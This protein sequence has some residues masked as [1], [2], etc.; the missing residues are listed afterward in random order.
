MLKKTVRRTRQWVVRWKRPH[1]RRRQEVWSE[2]VD[3]LFH[4]FRER[5]GLSQP[6]GV[7]ILKEERVD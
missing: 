1:L 5:G 7:D 3:D 6:V 4:L 2:P